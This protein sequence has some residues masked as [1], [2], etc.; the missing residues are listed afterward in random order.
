MSQS[1]NNQLPIGTLFNTIN[2]Y[3][4]EDLVKFL[5]SM[6]TQ[7]AMYVLNQAITSSYEKGI[8]TMQEVEVLSK[9]LRLI[10]NFVYLNNKETPTE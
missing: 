6:S 1:T 8:Y 5:E 2:Y 10:N 3:S 7:Q 9:S 4:T